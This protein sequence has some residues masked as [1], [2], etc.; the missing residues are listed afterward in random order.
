MK[1]IVLFISIIALTVSCTSVKQ[2]GSMNMV[3]NRNIDLENYYEL[4]ST[5][6]GG[7]KDDLKKTRA[8]SVEDAIDQTV[9]SVPGGEFLMNAKIY[10]IR[11][12]YFAVEGDVWGIK[13]RVTHRGFQIGD[14]VIWKKRRTYKTATVVSLKDNNSCIIKDSEG[15][16]RQAYYSDISLAE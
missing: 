7:N 5:Y 9:R 8:S 2:V 3:A 6:A 11:G 1:K 16:L 4:L 15:K 13:S 10:L 12:Q 14:D